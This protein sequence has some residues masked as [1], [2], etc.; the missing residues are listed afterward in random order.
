MGRPLCVERWRGRGWLSQRSLYLACWGC[1]TS[2]Q[3]TVKSNRGGQMSRL[4]ACQYCGRV[5]AADYN[6]GQ[7][8]G[9]QKA[10]T[11]AVKLRTCRKW[12]DTRKLV[13]DRDHHLCRVCLALHRLTAGCL[14]THHII[15]LTEDASLAYDPDNLITL[16]VKHHKAA[17][18]GHIDREVLRDLARSAMC[19]PPGG[20]GAGRGSAGYHEPPHK[21]EK[22]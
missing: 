10:E 8:P 7:R 1:S 6:C 19:I 17:D 18:R 22:F 15:P 5:H 3:N 14:E 13:N 16:C 11:E 21:R 20:K 9:R 4:K 12:D 2:L